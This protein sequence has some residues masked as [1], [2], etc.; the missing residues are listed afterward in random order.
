LIV[1]LT[2]VERN[3]KTIGYVFLIEWTVQMSV[4]QGGT[5]G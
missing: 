1:I 2:L 5:A 4:N 3:I